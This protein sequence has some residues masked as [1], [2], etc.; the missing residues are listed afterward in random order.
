[1][2]GNRAGWI[3]RV[4]IVWTGTRNHAEAKLSGEVMVKEEVMGVFQ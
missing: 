2:V 3:R 1:V 4:N